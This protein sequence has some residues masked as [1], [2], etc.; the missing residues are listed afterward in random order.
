MPTF[1]DRLGGAFGG[2][3]VREPAAFA[4]R[5]VIT[6]VLAVGVLV[7]LLQLGQAAVRSSSPVAGGTFVLTIAFL[8]AVGYGLSRDSSLGVLLFLLASM[9]AGTYD[10]NGLLALDRLA[11][12]A[13]AAA[14]FIEVVSGRRELERFGLTE[15]LMF[16]FVLLSV[17]S[18]I[19]PHDLDVVGEKGETLSIVRLISTGAFFPYAIFVLTR[20]TF[21]EERVIKRFL[22]FSV[23]VGIYCALMNIFW[24]VGFN[25]L[26]WPKSIIDPSAGSN[27]DR[28]QGIFLNPAVNGFVLVCTFIAAM[29]LAAQRGQRF[30][31]FAL[32][33][34]LLMLVSIIPTQT[35]SAYL[36]AA[37]VIFVSALFWTGFRRWYVVILLIV[38]A[39]V[40]VNWSTFT[41][42]DRSSG[43]VG[44]ANEAEDRLNLAATSIWAIEQRPVFGW[45]IGRF[46][47]LNTL[48]HKAWGNTQWERGYGILDHETPLGIGAELG[49]VGMV[50]WALIILSILVV[51]GRAWRAL[52]RSG[53]ESRWFAFAFW[54]VFIDYAI[55]ANLIDMRLFG[56][57]NSLFFVWAGI[58][59][60]LA[61]RFARAPARVE[62]TEWQE[63]AVTTTRPWAGVPARL[64]AATPPAPALASSG[65][66]SIFGDA[67]PPDDDFLGPRVEGGPVRPL[68]PRRNGHP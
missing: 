40:V 64:A 50:L 44:S 10:T 6:G 52:P 7:I 30:R 49:I 9:A 61:D 48:N 22:W 29:Y 20:Q 65:S 34:G 26:I 45:G 58:V 18:A 13:L 32:L 25:T 23:W 17:A 37:L 42:S 35:R 56:F 47:E 3:P 27:P 16:C 8:V 46:V 24:W 43:G 57:A 14:W 59:A 63:S 19:A 38:G 11:F 60:A 41:S 2:R 12:L 31:R 28:A 68:Q 54:C 66:G 51:S 62:R 15:F 4:R 39:V 67:P 1:T 21:R 55:T 36:A 33:A 5:L 53:I